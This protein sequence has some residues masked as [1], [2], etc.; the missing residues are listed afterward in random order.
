MPMPAAT[1]I[2]LEV[3]HT[4]ALCKPEDAAMNLKPALESGAPFLASRSCTVGLLLCH[5]LIQEV[6]FFLGQI[7]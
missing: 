4:C 3:M 5:A 2:P 7:S 6:I 1:P